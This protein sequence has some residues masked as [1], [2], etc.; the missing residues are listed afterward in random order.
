VEYCRQAIRLLNQAVAHDPTFLLAYCQLAHA[1]DLLYF[2][3][4][5]HSPARLAL[6]HEAL[7]KALQLGAN[8]G[9]P[10]LAVAWVSYHC[11]RDYEKALAELAIARRELPNDSSVPELTGFIARRQGQWRECISNLE[12]AAELDPQNVFLF[13]QIT[14]AYLG[15]RRYSDA[16]RILERVLAVAPED[17]STRVARALIDLD[18]RA[19][20]QLAY[21]AIQE[22]VMADPSAADAIAEQ[23]LY[24]ALCRRD[25]G[26]MA[27]ALAS[28]PPEGIIPVNVRM[29]RNFCDGIAA[30]ARG[31]ETAAKA[32]FAATREDMEKLVREQPDYAEALSVLGI[33]DAALDRTEEAV[34]A[35]RRAAALFPVTKDAVMGAE[36]L[37]NLAITYAWVG[38]KDLALKQ[39]DELVRI[40]SHISYGQLRLHPWWDP[41]RDDP[42]FEKIVEEAK[43]PVALK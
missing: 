27:R 21:D 7:D 13:Q 29:P 43:K 16:V 36:I 28:I 5:D 8:R 11:Y 31:D 30:R 38:E 25:S 37:R 22:L 41:L 35:G 24:L 2:L 15:L 39:L 10:H 33:A 42:R 26:E 6:A 9:E 4:L 17:P 20:T 14:Q 18:W 40:Y 12:R 19:E 34:R 23:W 1:H 32:A 3:G